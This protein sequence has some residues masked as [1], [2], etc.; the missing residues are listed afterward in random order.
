M[1]GGHAAVCRRPVELGGRLL[2][3]PYRGLVGLLGGPL[4]WPRKVAS[5][6]SDLPPSASGP[7]DAAGAQTITDGSF[8]RIKGDDAD[9]P[10]PGFVPQVASNN[11]CG[12]VS[13]SRYV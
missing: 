10:P 13:A 6:R 1:G 9:A 5:H 12:S 7:H 3:E 8:G 2:V 11:R 4:V